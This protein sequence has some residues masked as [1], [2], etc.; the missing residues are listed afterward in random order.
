MNTELED[1]IKS[2]VIGLVFPGVLIFL[3]VPYLTGH[4]T[5]TFRGLPLNSTHAFD[6]GVFLLGMAVC[7]HALFFRIYDNHPATKYAMMAAGIVA[8]LVSIYM[9]LQ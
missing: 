6:R 5:R 2:F 1:G 7:I 3:A 9:D 8:V 4:E